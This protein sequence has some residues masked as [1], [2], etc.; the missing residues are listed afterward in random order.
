MQFRR[1]EG[2]KPA[3]DVPWRS[4]AANNILLLHLLTMRYARVVLDNDSI[5]FWIRG[6]RGIVSSW[7]GETSNNITILQL[8]LLRFRLEHR[9][10]VVVLE[11]RLVIKHW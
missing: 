9:E 3:L 5:A 11:P 4:R 8:S 1:S 7:H 6:T 2:V 10:Y